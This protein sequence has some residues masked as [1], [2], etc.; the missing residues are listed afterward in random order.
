MSTTS[1][2]RP[3]TLTSTTSIHDFTPLTPAS[4]LSLLYA[5][6]FDA[7]RTY[8]LRQTTPSSYSLTPASA[9][10]SVSWNVKSNATGGFMNR[11][12]HMVI[13]RLENGI[14]SEFAEVRFELHGS[15]TSV[16]YKD[17]RAAQ[18]LVLESSLDQR[19]ACLVQG[20]EYWWQSLGPSRMVLELVDGAGER[21]ALFVY[22]G[23]GAASTE[24]GEKS[25]GKK[26]KKGGEEV[27]ELHMLEEME[28]GER[29]TEEVIC[30]ALAVVE[31]AKR[32]K[33]NVW[34][35]GSNYRQGASCGITASAYGGGL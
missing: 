1:L 12:P 13:S 25:A 3:P 27:G 2:T 22:A 19:Y 20:R 6:S 10:R 31:R 29:A 33:G 5:H 30:G 4:T 35:Q 15:G 14:G 17:G 8:A 23:E 9:A 18:K 32:R 26:K 16:L 24:M 21:V 7:L 28:G 11:K 34:T